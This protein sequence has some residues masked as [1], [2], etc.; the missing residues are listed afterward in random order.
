MHC[1]VALTD[2]LMNLGKWRPSSRRHWRIAK[3]SIGAALL[4]LVVHLAWSSLPLQKIYAK[5]QYDFTGDP[6]AS[7][8]QHDRLESVKREFLHAWSG[9]KAQSWMSDTL[10]PIS[11]GREDQFCGWSA[12]LIDSL[13]TL[14]IMSLGEEFDNAIKAAVTIDFEASTQNCQV[15]FFESTIRYLGGLL[16]AYDLS[17]DERLKPKLIELG[18]ILYSAF[19]TTTGLPCSH[20][21][22]GRSKTQDIIVPD[23][24]APLAD[25][26]SFSL[27]FTRLW[28][29]TGDSKYLEKVLSIS[30]IFQ[31]AQSGST[32]PGLWPER[33]DAT[34]IA[35]SYSKFVTSSTKYSLGALS[36]S[37]YEY[38]VKTHLMLGGRDGRF[39]KLWMSATSQIK[40]HLLFRAYIPQ[41][42]ETDTLF[43]GIVTKSH[44]DNEPVLDPRIEHLACFAGGMFALS[45]RIFKDPED[46]KLGEALTNGCVWAYDNGPLGIMPETVTLLQCPEPRNAQCEWN[47][48]IWEET[49]GRNL[50]YPPGYLRSID[51]Y[52]RLRPEA[53]ESL[54]VLYRIT[55]DLKWRDIGWKMFTKIIEHTRAPYG[56]ATLTDVMELH[57]QVIQQNHT[58]NGTAETRKMVAK[59][60]DQM[61][62]F[63]LAETLKY[64]YLL[65]SDPHLVSL[66]EFVLNTEAH[67]LRLMNS[68]RA[69]L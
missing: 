33:L 45:S 28:Q 46:L 68:T 39:A 26:F 29:I 60:K 64:F 42:N 69:Y 59:Q 53:V 51:T 27:E 4:I 5:V 18:E 32:I 1:F 43:A 3:Y 67:P 47:D 16:A 63:W 56:H 15:N 24:D 41:W 21:S 34:D 38:L 37:A 19:N 44:S 30:A 13:D 52:Y 20:C 54:F 6:A 40:Q 58:G 50:K 57:E 9:Y 36:D 55:G 66:D 8:V 61:E 23:Y 35:G 12:T 31:R 25:A 7:T 22:L 11:G 49:R 17:M 48:T 10:K 14:Y 2:L 65:F 62:S